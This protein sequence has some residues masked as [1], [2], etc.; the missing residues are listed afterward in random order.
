MLTDI[1]VRMTEHDVPEPDIV[2]TDQPE[3]EGILRLSA[4]RLVIEIFERTL[5][6]DLG[7]KAD[8]YADAGVPE[9][10]VIDVNER[11]VLMH[12]NPCP[13]G[14]GYDGQLDVPW[15][16]VLHAATIDGLAVETVGLS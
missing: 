5:A 4:A 9:Y 16:E 10:W 2:V 11:C 6:I 8:L 14:S 3:G 12:A 1:S 15:G 13:D 7:R